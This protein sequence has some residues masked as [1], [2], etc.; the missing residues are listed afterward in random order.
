MTDYTDLIERLRGRGNRPPCDEDRMEAA[1][2][3]AALVKERDHSELHREK[4]R[5]T[6]VSALARVK[7]LESDL[8]WLDRWLGHKPMPECVARIKAALA[9]GD[10]P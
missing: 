2:V 4:N 7:R 6:A 5:E 9:E 1:D 8:R 10:K 3:I